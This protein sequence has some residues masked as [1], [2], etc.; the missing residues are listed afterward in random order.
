[1]PSTDAQWARIEPLLPDRTPKR[2]G[3]WRDHHEVIYAIAYR[4][5][6]GAQWV[7]LPEPRASRSLVQSSS[8]RRPSRDR[9]DRGGY[10]TSGAAGTRLERTA[11]LTTGARE[12]RLLRVPLKPERQPR[13]RA[14]SLPPP[15]GEPPPALARRPG[16]LSV[17]SLFA[18]PAVTGT[19]DSRAVRASR[20]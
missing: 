9:A 16:A 11:T 15:S 1:M 8:G 14:S 19:E 12:P 20:E 10:A 5:Q 7:Y 13:N 4:F 17:R 2:G 6:A 3:R 18:F